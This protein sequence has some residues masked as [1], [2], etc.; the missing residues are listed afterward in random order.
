MAQQSVVSRNNTTIR[1]D[2]N[3]TV[4]TLHLTDVVRFDDKK[5]TL[6]TGGW[7][8]TTTMTRMMQAS[9]QFGLGYSVGRA[10]GKFNITTPQGKRISTD[11][12]VVTFNRN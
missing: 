5:I 7:L 9:R 11:N 3:E 12:S 10:G 4:V 2:G 6:N 1:K 8:T